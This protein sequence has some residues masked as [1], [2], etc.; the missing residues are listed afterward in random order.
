MSVDMS[1]AAVRARLQE[2]SRCVTDFTPARRLDTKIDMSRAGIARRL[3]EASDLLDLCRK[4]SA[5]RP[6]APGRHRA[7]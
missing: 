6:L 4:L 5:A 1:P 7:P 2:A 3:R